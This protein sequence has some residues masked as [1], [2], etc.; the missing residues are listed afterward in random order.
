MHR[1]VADKNEFIE[2]LKLA[3]HSEIEK[4]LN[5]FNAIVEVERKKRL[6]ERKEKR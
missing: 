1:M 3:R 4:K 2:K 6:Q 5:D